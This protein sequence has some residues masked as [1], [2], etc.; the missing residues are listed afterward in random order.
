MALV[1]VYVA[2]SVVAYTDY[3]RTQGEPPLDALELAGAQIWRRHNCQACHQIYGFGGFLGP[4]LTNRVTDDTAD[5]EF[6]EILTRGSGKMPAFRLSP[7]DREAVLAWLRA[8]HRTG[9]SQPPG[10]RAKKSV[11]SVYHLRHLADAWRAAQGELPP[12]VRRGIETWTRFRCGLCHTPFAEGRMRAPDLFAAAGDRSADAIATVLRAGRG[13][14]P[15][16]PASPEET[17]D[18]AA[19]LQWAAARRSELVGLNETLLERETF[20]WSDVPWFEY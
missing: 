9:R 18:L 12:E 8:I 6:T 3:P 1:A 13:R 20:S 5:D 19:F 11:D 7:A 14:M 4:D 17:A 16:F 2:V 15:P 10:L